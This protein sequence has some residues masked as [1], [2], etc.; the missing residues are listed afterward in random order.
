MLVIDDIKNLIG[1]KFKLGKYEIN[2]IAVEETVLN[3]SAKDPIV[4]DFKLP[5]SNNVELVLWLQSDQDFEMEGWILS[6][7]LVEGEKWIENSDITSLDTFK[8]SIQEYLDNC[9]E[10]INEQ[11]VDDF[12]N[13]K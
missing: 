12:Y 6:N 5:V 1:N 2:C 4:I 7:N 11:F 3:V 8:K 9:A 13:L 10:S